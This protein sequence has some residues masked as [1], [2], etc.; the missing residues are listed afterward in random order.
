MSTVHILSAHWPCEG[1]EILGVYATSEEAE[2]AKGENEFDTGS[3]IV[4]ILPHDVIPPANDGIFKAF[5]L[6]VGSIARDE[7]A[8]ELLLE[9]A[10]A[11]R[12]LD[13]DVMLG[14]ELEARG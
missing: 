13:F 11:G 9:H 10:Q 3:K 14:R 12:W 2:K 8:Y 5:K 7:T 6:M 4:E 1:L